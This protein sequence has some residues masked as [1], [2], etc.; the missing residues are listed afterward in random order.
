MSK[1]EINNLTV[2][3][4]EKKNSFTALKNVSFSIEEG[5]AAAEKAPC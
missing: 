5:G 1:I 4:T 3:Y 2:D